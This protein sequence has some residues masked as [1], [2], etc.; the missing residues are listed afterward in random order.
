LKTTPLLD[1]A[2]WVA[3]LQKATAVAYKP[4]R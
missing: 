2:Q 1:G 3:A 4:K